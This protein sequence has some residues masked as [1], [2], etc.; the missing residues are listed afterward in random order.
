MKKLL[1][2][3]AVVPLIGLMSCEKTDRTHFDFKMEFTTNLSALMSY[4]LGIHNNVLLLDRIVASGIANVTVS[5]FE[6]SK[7]NTVLRIHTLD[8]YQENEEYSS[9]TLNGT[10]NLLVNVK[11]NFPHGD[12]PYL[13]YWVNDVIKTGWG[14]NMGNAIHIEENGPFDSFTAQKPLDIYVVYDN[15]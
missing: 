9:W 12:I 8:N 7:D 15:L 5:I 11:I 13:Q 4:D 14:E 6:V 1:L 2:L 10:A 3:L